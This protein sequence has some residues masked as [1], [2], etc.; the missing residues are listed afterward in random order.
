MPTLTPILGFQKPVVNGDEDQWGIFLNN[1]WDTA[2]SLGAAAV[3]NASSNF[4]ISAGIFPEKFYLIT[5]GGLTVTGTLPDP[6][7]IPAGK[8]FTVKI[9]DI[10]GSINLVCANVAVLIDGQA[11]Y[12][13]NNQFAFVRLLA[14]GS[15][16]DVVGAG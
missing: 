15:G 8:L 4:L 3:V 1:D 13:L 11:S 12:F 10:G 14:D 6:G 2:D 16:Y 9:L 7:T 5:T